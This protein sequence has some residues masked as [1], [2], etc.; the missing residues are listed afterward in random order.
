MEKHDDEKAID[1][2]NTSV[3]Y[4]TTGGEA[5]SDDGGRKI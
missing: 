2:K 5:M 1:K 3:S 4:L